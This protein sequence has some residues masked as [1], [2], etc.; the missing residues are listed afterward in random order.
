MSL[1]TLLVP[2]NLVEQKF[3][4]ET[5]RS[6]A[7]NM[8]P[9]D[10]IV[11]Y[12]YDRVSDKKGSNP[13][14]SAHSPGDKILLLESATGSGKS[15]ILAPE[16]FKRQENRIAVTQPRILTTVEIPHDIIQRYK[17]LELGLNIGYQTGVLKNKPSSKGIVFMTTGVLLQQFISIPPEVMK[18]YY[19]FIIIDEVH[20]RDIY[21]DLLIYYIKKMLTEYYKDSSC[22]AVVFMSATFSYKLFADYFGINTDK[23]GYLQV[24]GSTYPI[25]LIYPEHDI[26]DYIVSTIGLIKD[27]HKNKD[28]FSSQV[29]DILVFVKGEKEIKAIIEGVDRLN[30]DKSMKQ[31]GLL[32]ALGLSR[33]ISIQNTKEYRDIF[34]DHRSL[35]NETGKKP[36]R[37][38]IIST[39]IAETGVTIKSLK[40]VIDTGYYL[41]AWYCSLYGSEVLST[42][43]VTQFM[44]TQRRGRVGRVAPGIF[45]PLYTLDSYNKMIKDQPPKIITDDIAVVLLSLILAECEA[46]FDIEKN[47]KI[48]YKSD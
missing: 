22:C 10:F 29:R 48:T 5:E 40:Y 25:K 32:Y 3:M 35:R 27:I 17:D 9:I 18:S 7:E 41:G 28:D 11:N 20:E 45:Y 31:F 43:S 44:S 14:I 46:E 2:G 26:S 8:R 39:N 47:N 42:N 16:L 4:N 23:G 36:T 33:S 12:L 15:T 6:N 30:E 21:L 13:R 37:R 1:P 19:K 24:S 38:V 34:T